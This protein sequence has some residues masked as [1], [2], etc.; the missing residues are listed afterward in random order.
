MSDCL[1]PYR[2][3]PAKVSRPH[4]GLSVSKRLKPCSKENNFSTHP[5]CRLCIRSTRFASVRH[6]VW[7]CA[8]V[9]LPLMG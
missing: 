9:V 6:E 8:V 1:I 4:R 3:D 5:L 2:V 7:C